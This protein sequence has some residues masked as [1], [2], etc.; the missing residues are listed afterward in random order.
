MKLS[1]LFEYKLF[2]ND[3]G[4]KIYMNPSAVDIRA[5]LKNSYVLSKLDIDLTTP[6]DQLQGVEDEYEY[7]GGDIHGLDYPLRGI[8]ADGDVY[9]VDSFDAEHND[10]GLALRNQGVDVEKTI[11]IAIEKRTTAPRGDLEDYIIGTQQA[12][13]NALKSMP[14]VTRMKM[15]IGGWN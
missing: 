12:R 10:L 1:E 6:L 15:P 7:Y 8:V 14:M 2:K 3:A 4:F 5:I 11:H 13:V 9:I